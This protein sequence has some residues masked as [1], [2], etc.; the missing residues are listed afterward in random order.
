MVVKAGDGDRLHREAQALRMLAPACVEVI[1]L[2][3]FEDG[4]GELTTRRA[5]PGDD[6]R[7]LARQD[8]DAATR[9]IAD[10]IVSMREGCAQ[11]VRGDE[12]MPA[13][14]DVLAPVRECRDP[15]L[16][17]DLIDAALGIGAELAATGEPVVLHG[18]LQHRNI[19]R[20]MGE[21]EQR[22]VALDPHG[23]W[24]D[25]AFEAAP[26]LVAPESLL[27][28]SDIA[29]ARGVAGGPLLQRT[30]RRIGILAEVTGDD[31]E[32]LWAWAF[33]GSLIAEARMVG[34]HDLVHGAPLALALALRDGRRI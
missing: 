1:D 28:G 29:D 33:V 13:L 21:G 22:W 14:V 12:S 8:D 6:L 3:R 18:D 4:S 15:R 16:P 2:I 25:R 30:A 24:G 5:L 23:W 34:L 27:M 32:R 31:P 19:A 9:I 20:S 11:G 10:V 17:H 7:P 26:I